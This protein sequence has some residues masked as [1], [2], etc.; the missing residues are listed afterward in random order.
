MPLLQVRSLRRRFLRREDGGATV[1]AV[2]WLPIF[3]F[4]LF[5]MVDTALIFVGQSEALRVVQDANRNMSI[6][7]FRT[8]EETEAYV[9]R[10]LARLSPSVTAVS[11]VN[12]GIVTTTVT[13]PAGDLQ[14]SGFFTAVINANLSISADH[15]IENWD[16]TS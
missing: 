13:M 2:I 5:L 9:E 7:R 15:L 14:M 6:G 12:A 1:E 3:F 8:V 4:V 10:Q 11:V 16:A